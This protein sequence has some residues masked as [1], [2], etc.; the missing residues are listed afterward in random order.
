MK[1]CRSRTKPFANG[2]IPPRLLLLNE[3]LHEEDDESHGGKEQLIKVS[4]QLTAIPLP[5]L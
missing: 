4:L 3:D 2:C 5:P 1:I